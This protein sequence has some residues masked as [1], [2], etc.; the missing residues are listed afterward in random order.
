MG[1]SLGCWVSEAS[2]QAPSPAF[3]WLDSG[4]GVAG[5]NLLAMKFDEVSRGQL[6]KDPKVEMSDQGL[7][8]PIM[9]GD[10]DPRIEQAERLRV[11]GKEAF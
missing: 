4:K 3:G 7:I 10:S 1:I 11:A 6:R 2:A 5:A 8:G 9:A